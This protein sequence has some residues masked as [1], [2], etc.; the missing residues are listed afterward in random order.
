[1][2]LNF[3]SPHHSKVQNSVVQTTHT[4][5]KQILEAK[6]PLTHGSSFWA[7]TLALLLCELQKGFI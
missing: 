1:M 2:Y 4:F 3:L 7:L 5:I 6:P